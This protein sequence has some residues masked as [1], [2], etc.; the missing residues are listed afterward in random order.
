VRNVD[1]EINGPVYVSNIDCVP[2]GRF[3][4]KLVVVSMRLMP[5]S[6][7]ASAAAVTEAHPEVHGGPVHIGS[8]ELL[9]ISDL[10]KPD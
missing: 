1:Q 9:G 3:H 5:P 10:D 4:G 6:L 8:P 7:V 2:A